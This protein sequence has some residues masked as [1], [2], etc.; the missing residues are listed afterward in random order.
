MSREAAITV[1]VPASLKARLSARAQRQHRSL[2]GQV[3]YELEQALA[4]ETIETQTRPILGLFEGARVPDDRDLREVR[5]LL[6]GKLGR[7]RR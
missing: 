2:S 7:A 6:W 1:R 4:D 5:S 3:V